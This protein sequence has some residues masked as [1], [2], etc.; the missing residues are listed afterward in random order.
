M[1]QTD[2]VC[3]IVVTVI[4]AS[5]VSSWRVAAQEEEAASRDETPER[6][7]PD[8]EHSKYL[9]WNLFHHQILGSP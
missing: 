5:S 6:L 4:L 9:S 7:T 3:G 8:G 2:G 1:S